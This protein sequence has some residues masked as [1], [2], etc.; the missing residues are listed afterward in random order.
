MVAF[1]DITGQNFSRW[2]VVKRNKSVNKNTMWEC[3]CSCGVIRSVNG[4][5]L[6]SG[7]S[8][9]CGCYNLEEIIKRETTHGMTGT[10]IYKTWREMHTRCYN[11]NRKSYIDYGGRDINICERWLKFENFYA[12]MGEKPKGMSI[13]RKNNDGNYEPSNCRWAT[14]QQQINNRRSSDKW[15]FKNSPLSTNISGI[16]GVSW[17]K[18]DNKWMASICINKKQKNLGRFDTKE[19]AANAYQSAALARKKHEIDIESGSI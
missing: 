15:N 7:K 11:K 6:K 9:S 16:R 4:S 3:L 12:D 13:D 2:I 17:C 1:I 19:Q 10:P 18:R 5:D 14:K 8:K